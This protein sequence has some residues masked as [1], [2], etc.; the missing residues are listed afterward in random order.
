[1]TSKSTE[2]TQPQWIFN[3]STGNYSL[4]CSQEYFNNIMSLLNQ[5]NS[6]IRRLN[7]LVAELQ[8][9]NIYTH[10]LLN[11]F[12]GRT[13]L[14]PPT[15]ETN[16]VESE[17]PPPPPLLEMNSVQPEKED[18]EEG[19]IIISRKPTP[20]FA[21]DPRIKNKN[22]KEI[23]KIDGFEDGIKK[24]ALCKWFMTKKYCRY[25]DKCD[26]AH[27]EEELRKKRNKRSRDD[28]HDHR[29]SRDRDYSRDWDYS[30]DRDYSSYSRDRDYSHVRRDKYERY[31]KKRRH[32]YH[33]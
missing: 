5:N 10:T 30:R 13:T 22:K 2:S 15:I 12:S 3:P 32:S 9:D 18:I 17:I 29:Y 21:N 8:Q 28:Y 26:F 24:T 1:M 25:G 14:S 31:S 23:N 6:G 19:E 7:E 4:T 11:Q 20:M 33:Y 27:G 16:I